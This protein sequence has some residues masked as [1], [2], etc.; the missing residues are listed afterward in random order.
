[1][2]RWTT[3]SPPGCDPLVTHLL[4]VN[5]LIALA[6]RDHVLHD[7]AQRWFA[8]VGAL[9]WATATVTETGFVR[10]SM[11]PR[12][13]AHAVSWRAALDMLVA[14]RGTRGHRRLEADVDLLA[15]PLVRRAAVAGHR[16]VTD[17]HLAA[18][19]A[20]HGA[21]LATLD[22]GVAEA[23]HPDDRGVVAI[24]PPI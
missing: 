6:W 19:A 12:V 17:V 9:G 5:L 21:R 24:V 15:A 18:L 23:L 13:T 14:M 2:R 3:T 16:Q 10:V 22:G 1:M 20:H 11:N 7:A 4:D 8:A